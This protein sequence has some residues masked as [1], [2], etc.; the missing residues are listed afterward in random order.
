MLQRKHATLGLILAMLV[1]SMGVVLANTPVRTPEGFDRVLVYLAAG[2]YDPTVPPEEGDLAMWFHEE[3]MGRDDEEIQAEKEAAMEYFEY[4]FGP[5]LPEPVAFGVDPRNEYRLY[6]FS[7]MDAPSEGWVVRD[8]GFMIVIPAD[9]MLHGEWGGLAGKFV[10]GGSFL[11]HG[12]YNID[13]T[14]P[15]KSGKHPSYVAPIIIH[16]QSAEPIVPDPINGVTTFR[17]TVIAPW[18]EGI[19]QGVSKPLTMDGMRQANIRN[20]L[21][22]PAFGPS[23]EH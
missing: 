12:D 22:F 14:G 21:T 10:P 7:G 8:G 20:I 1:A 15:G 23:I 18:D 3:I 5:G 2:K 16:Y 17:C 11:V 19:A 13:M 6:Y 9:T 4:M